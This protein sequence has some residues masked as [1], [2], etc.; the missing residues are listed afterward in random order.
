MELIEYFKELNLANRVRFFD[1]STATIVDAAKAVG[2]AEN[3]IAKTLSFFLQD[4]RPI[5]IV[6]AGDAKIDNA[7]YKAHFGVKAKMIPKELV[8]EK[9]GYDVGGVCPFLVSKDIDIYLD[10]SLKRFTTTFAAVGTANSAVELSSEELELASKSQ[11]WIDVC[12][13][14]G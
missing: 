5:L 14:S 9:I 11:N 13:V 3:R 7:K 10:K 12:K 8:K 1:V 2:V 4:E 6:V